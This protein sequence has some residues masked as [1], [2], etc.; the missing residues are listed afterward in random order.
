MSSN[1]SIWVII[2]PTL[3]IGIIVLLEKVDCCKNDS[4]LF[5]NLFLYIFVIPVKIDSMKKRLKVLRPP[6]TAMSKTC[7]YHGTCL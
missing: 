1:I 7:N 4:I 6:E 3:K 2:V 5:L